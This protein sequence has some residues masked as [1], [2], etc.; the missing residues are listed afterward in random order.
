M[1]NQSRSYVA[2]HGLCKLQLRPGKERLT[3]KSVKLDHCRR[4]TIRERSS[5]K[6][7]LRI[8]TDTG[9]LISI[10]WRTLARTFSVY[11][12]TICFHSCIHTVANLHTPR[13][14]MKYIS[15]LQ[16][17][18]LKIRTGTSVRQLI[19]SLILNSD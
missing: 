11:Y 17:I 1:V 19:K 7:K 9:Q 2:P 16:R 13:R 18:Y 6:S 12:W 3:N 10:C 8:F 5:L 14:S 4:L 15:D